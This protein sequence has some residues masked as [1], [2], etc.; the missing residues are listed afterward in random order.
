LFHQ[1]KKKEMSKINPQGG[2]KKLQMISTKS[3]AAKQ[4]GNVINGLRAKSSAVDNAPGLK[5]KEN[6]SHA[7][8]E[9]KTKKKP[10]VVE[11]ASQVEEE[12]EEEEEEIEKL[13]ITTDN[14]HANGSNEENKEDEEEEPKAE[15]EK[16]PTPT[17]KKTTSTAV[18]VASSSSSSSSSNTPKNVAI[19]KSLPDHVETMIQSLVKEF[20]YK[21]MESMVKKFGN[22]DPMV[23]WHLTKAEDQQET[24]MI[25][26]SLNIHKTDIS[27]WV[28]KKTA[29]KN[30]DSP[31]G[32]IIQW[33]P[34]GQKADTVDAPQWVA[35]TLH[36]VYM[37][38]SLEKKPSNN[39]QAS[40]TQNN[41]PPKFYAGF[42]SDLPAEAVER[43]PWFQAAANLW[44]V[45]T[46]MFSMALLEKSV[47]PK[48][49]DYCWDASCWEAI[50][51]EITKGNTEFE[52]L[53]KE[54]QE[55]EKLKRFFSYAQKIFNRKQHNNV[56]NMMFNV[57][58]QLLR[59]ANKREL[60]KFE[61][62]KASLNELM[63]K[64]PKAVKDVD[65][66]MLTKKV[67]QHWVM[68]YV[69]KNGERLEMDTKGL[70]VDQFIGFPMNFQFSMFCKASD[71]MT[72]YGMQGRWNIFREQ[73]E[74]IINRELPRNVNTEPA[75]KNAFADQFGG[76]EPEK[77]K[78]KEQEKEAEE[79]EEEN[80]EY[81]E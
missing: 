81:N 64:N 5:R 41:G 16:A 6:S 29:Y 80:D 72:E 55:E 53:P 75:P 43:V 58:R 52:D 32:F 24:D 73:R 49:K 35:P 65:L 37:G 20:N 27:K 14:G 38:T 56:W 36:S 42:I 1:R 31:K 19:R 79:E 22:Y 54:K 15:E 66:L 10:K 21:N 33:G 50:A 4:P 63:K 28:P 74:I 67:P 30:A 68:P 9:E 69:E 26:N 45:H 40:T 25:R 23:L 2:P 7:K 44:V 47:S 8:E 39:P 11:E 46:Y 17:P 76:D 34:P 78:A 13:D 48:H 57:S 3:G 51:G 59:D 61:A 70:D 62:R 71:K 12:G 77:P 60:E 18:V